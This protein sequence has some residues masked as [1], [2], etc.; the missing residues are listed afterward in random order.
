[1][2]D[3]PHYDLVSLGDLSRLV[4]HEL[5]LLVVL[6]LLAAVAFVG[7]RAVAQSIEEQGQADAA[8]WFERG[9]A[10][11]EAGDAAGAV[12]ALREATFRAKDT[13]PYA[14][15]LSLALAAS[16]QR[17]T[18]S[19]L[20]NRWRDREPENPAI[21]LQ[22]ARIEAYSGRIAEATAAY[23]SALY[24]RWA[25]DAAAER[26]EV[27]RELIHFLL[28]H[29]DRAGALSQILALG[30][31]QPDT[32]EAYVDTGRLLLEAGDPA[33]ALEQFQRAIRADPDSARALAGAGQAAFQQGDDA[34][35]IRYLEQ[36]GAEA[37]P[38]LVARARAAVDAD[39]LRRGLSASSRRTRLLAA[40]DHAGARLAAC[41]PDPA[42]ADGATAALADFRK[43]LTARRVSEEPEIVEEGLARVHA[44]LTGLPTSCPP[45]SRD[46]VY[47][48]VGARHRRPAA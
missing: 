10:R 18:A 13:W 27:R 34:A 17:E 38:D 4:R 6:A 39:P 20:L 25:A 12:A 48:R 16:G 5:V 29:G 19:Q 30:S 7:T 22:L 8:A 37:D 32:E 41:P 14:E 31:S 2:D 43:S 45:D 42:A 1:M 28:E 23:E 3:T 33:R 24:G 21:P 47:L 35:A 15:A 46:A 11:M 40:V 26:S 36:A 9:R 44:L